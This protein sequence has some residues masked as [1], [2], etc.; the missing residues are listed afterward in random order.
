MNLFSLA[1][2][3]LAIIIIVPIV[4]VLAVVIWVISTRNAL[5]SLKNDTEEGFSTIDVSLKKRWDLIPN[6]VETVKGYASH[7]QNTLTGVIEA[8]NKAM[9][10]SSPEEKFAAENALTGTLRS[11]FALKEAYPDL[12]ASQQFSMLQS[13]LSAIENEIAQ[14][15]KY[16]NATVKKF[17]NKI[18]FFPSNLIAKSMKLTKKAYFEAEEGER[19]NVQVKF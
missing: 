15:R 2:Y 16:Y 18:M 6:L 17:N 12:K 8:R 11:L 9:T 14:N 5:V 13:Q 10:A 7:E 4:I 3:I 1:T 19:Q